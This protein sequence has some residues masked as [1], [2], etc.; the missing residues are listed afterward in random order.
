MREVQLECI[1]FK[2]VNSSIEYLLMKRI[3]SK[4]GFWQPPSGGL[5]E[6]DKSKLDAAFRELKEEANINKEDVIKVIENVHYFT[7]D[8]HYLTNEPISPI[9]E[10][11]FGFE[12]KENIDIS[13][14]NNIDPEHEEIKWVQFEEALNLL[15]WE[16]NK[17][18]FV[19]INH[20]L[21]T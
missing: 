21:H 14:K 20:L 19:K 4:G 17:E 11:V 9:H 2:R 7:V 10:F 8:K 3:P 13:I 5:E 16:N 18:A 12:V 1:V 6:S 15:K